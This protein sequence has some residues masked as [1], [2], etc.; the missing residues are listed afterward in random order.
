[1]SYVEPAECVDLNNSLSELM[2]DERREI[3][4]ILHELSQHIKRD[5]D[6]Y[7]ANNATLGILDSYFARAIWGRENDCCI[8]Q[9]ND[10]YDLI[11]EKGR[12]PLIDRHKVI[13]N[14]Y[15]MINP[16]NTIL[17]TGP[18][19]GGKTVSLK[20]IG[21]FALMHQCAI[22]LPANEVSLPVYDNIFCD[23]GD[24]QS[25]ADDLSTFSA[26]IANLAYIT[27]HA[28]N[29]SLVILDELGSGTDPVEGQAL[30][31]SVLDFLRLR[32]VYTV[33]T[34]HYAQL[35]AYGQQHDEIMTSSVQFD[36]ENLKPT[37]L[38]QENT[39]GRSNALEIAKRLGFNQGIIDKAYEFRDQQQQPQDRLLENLQKQL[40]IVAQQR[41]KMD[42]EKQQILAEREELQKQQEKLRSDSIEVMENAR[43]KA[44][45]M[46]E[47]IREE[48]EEIISELKAMEAYRVNEVSAAKGKIS[49]LMPEQKVETIDDGKP[50]QVGDY[51]M[52]S[53]T[54][55]RGE[56]IEI[57]RKN[58]MVFCDGLKIRS[59]LSNLIRI[60]KPKPKKPVS[61]KAK[62]T[63]VN[64]AFKMELNLIGMR[65]EEALEALDKY[66]DNAVV[67][68]AP[69]VRIIHGVGTGAVRSAVWKRLEKYKFVKKYEIAAANDGGAGATLV[70]LGSS[71]KNAGK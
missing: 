64:P 23:I 35:K 38:Y 3:Q 34:T 4:R 24:N 69:F 57:D 68:N 71:D 65:V 20:L 59:S 50:L 26:H 19:T 32:K 31:S 6:G 13:A 45:E 7:L 55:Q 37:Y 49:A 43:T 60:E 10:R 46:I 16:V 41:E 56:I 5:A 33:A 25:I 17:I 58:A 61:T 44:A 18:N 9:I 29:H 22:P 51:V 11:I 54:S 47:Q 48:S 67:S 62:V 14:S 66:M 53:Q 12:H 27:S 70:T 8:S 2:D 30:A 39:I 1:A 21:L 15:H 28:T 52:I 42:L 63:R 36:E 40:D